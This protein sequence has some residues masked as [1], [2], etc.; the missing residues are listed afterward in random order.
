MAF[1]PPTG[2]NME[3]TW[4]ET[5]QLLGLDLQIA[6]ILLMLLVS[7]LTDL[8]KT[9]V[10]RLGQRLGRRRRTAPTRPLDAWPS[11]EWGP[12]H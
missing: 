4:L 8:V 9:T 5:V 6:A 7:G 1:R 3:R 11:Q 2:G 12:S 10:R